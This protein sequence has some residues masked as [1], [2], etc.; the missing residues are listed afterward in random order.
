MS[1]TWLTATISVVEPVSRLSKNNF[2]SELTPKIWVARSRKTLKKFAVTDQSK[3]KARGAKS[4]F[5]ERTKMST[6]K[7][8][9][10]NRKELKQMR[11]SLLVS[12]VMAPKST[13]EGCLVEG[14]TGQELSA[15]HSLQMLLRLSRKKLLLILPKPSKDSL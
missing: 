4:M 7:S 10:L 6:A 12:D 2:L 9:N 13:E 11:I 15:V 5:L 8:S 14:A 1:R 3:Q